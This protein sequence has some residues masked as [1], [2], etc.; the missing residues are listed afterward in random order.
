MPFKDKVKL[1]LI[2]KAF[3]TPTAAFM[4][5]TYL[6]DR[7]LLDSYGVENMTAR[8]GTYLVTMTP[9]ILPGIWCGLHA[10]SWLEDKFY[11]HPVRPPSCLDDRVQPRRSYTSVTTD[12]N[13]NEDI[14]K[15]CFDA[16]PQTQ[17]S[18]PMVSPPAAK[19]AD[20]PSTNETTNA[21]N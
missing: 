17:P 20:S 1:A 8:V 21:A 12:A 10:G 6:L 5:G 14:G 9:M 2:L 4:A 16:Q 18:A 19:N 7:Y 15:R 13:S 11:K 3:A